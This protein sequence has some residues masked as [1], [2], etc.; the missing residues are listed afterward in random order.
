[1]FR[2]LSHR[3]VGQE[4][5]GRS[6]CPPT[7][8]GTRPAL[9]HVR[10]RSRYVGTDLTAMCPLITTECDHLRPTTAPSAGSLTRL[11]VPALLRSWWSER[12][13]LIDPE[14]TRHVE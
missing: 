10:L 9:K 5:D 13:H 7:L 2:V 8:A 14:A 3:P 6:V 4:L 11:A 1:M 12:S